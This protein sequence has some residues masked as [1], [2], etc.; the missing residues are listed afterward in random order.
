MIGDIP[1][2]ALEPLALLDVEQL[3]DAVCGPA[4]AVAADRGVE[5]H[6]HRWQ[7]GAGQPALQPEPG[8]LARRQLRHRGSHLVVV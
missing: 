3:P 7:A 1:E 6:P 2:L 4:V 8:E 5:D